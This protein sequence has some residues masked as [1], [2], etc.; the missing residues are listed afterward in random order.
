MTRTPTPEVAA[1]PLA[2]AGRMQL[3]VTCPRCG[4][5]HRHLDVGLR[6]GPCGGRYVLVTNAPKEPAP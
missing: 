6:R 4:G 5:V 2:T 3:L 1:R